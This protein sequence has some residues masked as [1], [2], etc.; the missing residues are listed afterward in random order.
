[1]LLTERQRVVAEAGVLTLLG[2]MAATIAFN[3][4]PRQSN[5]AQDPPPRLDVG[6]TNSASQN[7]AVDVDDDG[8]G[9][10]PPGLHSLAGL[11][12]EPKVKLQAA[13]P[14]L[15][16]GTVIRMGEGVHKHPEPDVPQ[17]CLNRS[18]TGASGLAPVP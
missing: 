9:A 15:P 14:T 11:T 2:W 12:H 16:A 13:P 7:A 3:N 6:K 4:P 1:M 8:R 10:L 5:G 17:P 18:S